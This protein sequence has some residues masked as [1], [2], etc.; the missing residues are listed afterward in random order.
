MRK[1]LFKALVLGGVTFILWGCESVEPWEKGE[2]A[3]YTMLPER[4]PLEA[5][6]ADHVYYTR[7][8]AH[9]G[10]GVGG[11]GCGCN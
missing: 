11:G 3:Q 5:S 7:E 2:L 4:D 6:M 10:A 1:H 9:G 8:A